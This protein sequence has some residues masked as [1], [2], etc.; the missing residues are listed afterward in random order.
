MMIMFG[1]LGKT[2]DIGE[3]LSNKVKSRLFGSQG[4]ETIRLKMYKKH[5]FRLSAAQC[6]LVCNYLKSL[7]QKLKS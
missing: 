2:R 6:M 4:R 5:T 7:G 1:E 3:R